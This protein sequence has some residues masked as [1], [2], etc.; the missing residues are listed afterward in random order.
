MGTRVDLDLT[1]S[2]LLC[3]RA[4][5]TEEYSLAKQHVFKLVKPGYMFQ[6]YSNHQAYLQSLVEL[7]MLNA[8]ATRNPSSEAKIFTDGNKKHEPFSGLKMTY[9]KIKEN[10]GYKKKIFI[11]FIIFNPLN[12]SCF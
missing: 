4:V 6:L 11:L 5:G 2:I 1:R 9:K 10:N 8:Y 12:G 3:V 7:C